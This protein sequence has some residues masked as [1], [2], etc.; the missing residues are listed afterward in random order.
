MWTDCKG[1]PDIADKL[2]AFPVPVVIDHM[3]GFDVAAGINAPGFRCLLSLV[4]SGRI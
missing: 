3:G 4:E 1:L 2:R